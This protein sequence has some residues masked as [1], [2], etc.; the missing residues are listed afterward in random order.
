ME[1]K[2]HLRI[3]GDLYSMYLNLPH[4]RL[5]VDDSFRLI[6]TPPQKKLYLCSGCLKLRCVRS[7]NT[8]KNCEYSYNVL[9]L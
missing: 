5:V 3:I 8:C 7:F 2:T 9:E 6:N 4:R 1:K